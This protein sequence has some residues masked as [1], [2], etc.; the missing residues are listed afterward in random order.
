VET[1]TSIGI[2][3]VEGDTW[4]ISRNPNESVASL[5]NA[6]SVEPALYW[7]RWDATTSA[8]MTF[9][10]DEGTGDM[11]AW[12]GQEY[13][14][15]L[16]AQGAGIL[17]TWTAGKVTLGGGS[18]YRG[19]GSANLVSLFSGNPRSVFVAGQMNAASP[20]NGSLFA[21][22][23]AYIRLEDIA[24][25]S[26]G[27][28]SYNDGSSNNDYP[29]QSHLDTPMSFGY[30]TDMTDINW[31]WGA[32]TPR[33]GTVSGGTFNET[34][35]ALYVG[36]ANGSNTTTMDGDVYEIIVYDRFVPSAE[37]VGI[38]SYLDA[39][40][41]NPTVDDKYLVTV[42]RDVDGIIEGVTATVV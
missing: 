40:W 22:P 19:L 37:A 27:N 42:D 6:E 38:L 29:V 26:T 23:V 31:W 5:T 9:W 8:G 32:G 25:S 24:A 34:L 14:L 17:P 4:T 15:A 1:V 2:D 28:F 33:T 12:V 18:S 41:V 7:D 35:S 21:G 36:C 16:Y 10:T 39:K 30:T 3:L 13:G 20:Q 11:T